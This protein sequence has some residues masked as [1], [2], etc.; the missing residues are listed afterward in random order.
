MEIAGHSEKHLEVFLFMGV[1]EIK[2]EKKPLNIYI[3]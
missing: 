1:Y 3:L 2:E